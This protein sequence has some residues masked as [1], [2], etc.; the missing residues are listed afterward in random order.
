MALSTDIVAWEVPQTAKPKLPHILC[1]TLDLS[2]LLV[3]TWK[4]LPSKNESLY[5][6]SRR[7]V[8]PLC[9]F[10][11]FLHLL[12]FFFQT[13]V[14]HLLSVRAGQHDFWAPSALQFYDLWLRMRWYYSTHCPEGDLPTFIKKQLSL[15]Y[16]NWSIKPLQFYDMKLG[17]CN[18]NVMDETSGSAALETKN[19]KLETTRV[20]LVKV[21][22][23]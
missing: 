17:N 7:N 12:A 5:E 16:V 18:T 3:T 10:H 2:V 9:G 23:T 19:S 11:S 1:W 20:A 8:C 15:T 4:P 13:W 21:T 14:L 22:E 6:C